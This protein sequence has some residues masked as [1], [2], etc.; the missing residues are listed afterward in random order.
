MNNDDLVFTEG[1]WRGAGGGKFLVY[2]GKHL[3][4][5][6]DLD[7][8]KKWVHKKGALG[9]IWSYD[10]DCGQEGPW[11]HYVCDTIDYDVDKIKKKVR[12]YVRRGLESCT[13]RPV[14][15]SWL[16]DNGYDVYINAVSRYS[17]SVS[18]EP[19]D[20][21]SYRKE[22]RINSNKPNLEAIGVF[23]NKKLAAYAT[24]FAC[25]ER[26][27]IYTSQF[28]PAYSKTYPMYALYYTIA[29]DYLKKGYKEIDNGSRPLLHETNIGA[30]LLRLG[31]RKA[32][33]RLGIYF[34]RPFGFIIAIVRVF[35]G[36]CKFVLPKRK[37]ARLE[38]LLLARNIARITRKD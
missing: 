34:R 22:M 2:K 28:D 1:A 14:E 11:Y 32:Y 8:V 27:Q 5:N 17:G 33:C 38:S 19:V 9:A 35:R 21:E 13:V 36:V 16:A 29:H 31:W 23:V 30:F 7:A 24:L 4:D 25:G 37:Y 6:L 3:R 26:V 12:Y 10:Y 15:C 20:R 18:S